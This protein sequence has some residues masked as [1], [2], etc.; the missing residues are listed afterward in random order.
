MRCG[1]GAAVLTLGNLSVAHAQLEAPHRPIRFTRSPVEQL[2]PQSS[3]YVIHQDRQGFLWFATR[4]GLGRWDGYEVRTWKAN[5]FDS[6]AL[7]SNVIRR[8]VEDRDGSLWL[9]VVPTDRR[10]SVVARMVGPDHQRVETYSHPDATPFLDRDGTAWLAGLDSLYRFDPGRRR[11]RG[12]MARVLPGVRPDQGLTDRHG[13]IW[14]GTDSGVIERYDPS[15]GTAQRVAPPGA[16]PSSVGAMTIGLFEDRDGSLWVTGRGLRRIDRDRIRV[17]SIP[18]LGP[19][20]DTL[21]TGMMLQDPDGWL[22]LAT[23]DGVYRFD[24]ALTSIERHSLLEPGDPQTHN[25]VVGLLRDSGGS[26]WAGTVW[27]L[28]RHDPWAKAFRLLAHDRH[29]AGSLGG[30]LV[31]SILEDVTGALWIGTLGGGLNRID[32]RTGRVHRFVHHAADPHSLNHDWV[33]SLA[34]AGGGRVWAGTGAGFAL[35]DP[36]ASRSVTRGSLSPAPQP[37]A[38]TVTAVHVDSAGRLWMGHGGAVVVRT[39]D[40]ALRRLELPVAADVQRF[41]PD[42][43]GMWIGTAAG[44]VHL[45][46][47]TDST[48]LYRHD[49]ADRASLSHDVVLSLHRDRAGRLWVGT[50]SG[51][52]LFLADSGRFISYGERDGFRST[53]I[54]AILEDDNG[55]LWL[56]TNRGLVRFDPA[57]PAEARVRVYGPTAGVG[58]VEF[59]RNAGYRGRDGTLYFGGDKGV[60]FFDPSSILDNPVVPPVVL[61][62]LQRSTRAG[63]ATSRATT[64]SLVVI[65]PD[66]YTVTFQFAA[67]N[68]SNPE[69]NQYAYRLDG[70][71]PNWVESGTSRTASYT[72]LPA[73]RYVLRVRAANDDGLWNQTGLAIPV[74]VRP[75]YWETWWFRS[76]GLVAAFGVVSAATAVSLKTRHRRQLQAVRYQKALE[77]ERA[78]ISRDMHD[79]VGASLTEIAMLSE[80][81]LQRSGNGPMDRRPLEKIAGRSRAM[82]DAIGEIIWAIN[83]SNDRFDHLA[84]YL[85]AYAAD[86]LE[87][88]GLEARLRIDSGGAAL[89]VTAEFRRDVFLVLKES[90]AN[91]ARH[92]GATAVEVDLSLAAGWLTLQVRDDGRGLPEGLSARAG[93]GHHGLANL[94]RRAAAVHGTIRVEPAPGGGTLVRLDAP[95]PVEAGN[96]A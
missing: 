51:L 54:N 74:V 38:G 42:G 57:A 32:Q 39:A 84:A 73:G 43:D 77:G 86:F 50:N 34:D 89:P 67:L 71:D 82:L 66:E 68:Y 19:S 30:G 63:T 80:L 45:D 28:Y 5:P 93:S 56:S 3:V 35:V 15:S 64:D 55:R 72:N 25:W 83:P 52:N 16:L 61:T 88:A 44:L 76:L 90:L 81:A 36:F 96:L 13:V 78:R 70:F 94:A 8:L 22:W 87:S 41:L 95:L 11:F 85:R 27:G 60:T 29:D 46:L 62:A 40:G 4:E 7:P 18:G 92:A 91:V 1:L 59:N 20:L 9:Y 24:P 17:D 47:R 31:L 48:H 26:I 14:V 6:L 49:P 10:A 37:W 65:A 12:V 23:L 75:A 33:W 79:E 2:L 53:V 69:R 58:N 21:S